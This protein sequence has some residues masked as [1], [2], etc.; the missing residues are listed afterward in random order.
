MRLNVGVIFGGK[1]VEHEISIISATEIMGFMDENKYKVIPIYIDKDNVWY[2]G[3]HLK[4]IINYRD[5]ALVKRYAKRVA[6]V[7]T[8]H[9]FALQTLGFIKR[10]V[11]PVDVILPIGHGTFM[12]DGSLQGYLNMIG[13]PYCGCGVTASAIG[14]DKVL[15]KEVLEFNGI[16]TPKYVWF[17]KKEWVNDRKAIL[18]KLNDF[19]YPLFVK[20]ASLGSSIGISKVD[21]ESMLSK[22][23]KDALVYDKKIIIEEGIRN[24]KEVNISVLGD[25][26]RLEVSGIEEINSNDEFYTFKEKYVSDCSKLSKNKV[27]KSKPIISKEMI[28]DLKN[29]ALRTFKTINAS[30]VARIDFLVDEKNMKIY[31]NEINTIPG[32][33]AGWLWIEKKKSQSELVD[34]LINLAI[35]KYKNSKDYEYTIS[36]NLLEQFDILDGK[37]INRKK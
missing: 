29:L 8:G 17:Y 19:S 14:Q 5:I 4:S 21:N 27:R 25:Y 23:I 10:N 3:D 22:A 37:K 2:T 31:V 33:L 9:G 28:E 11:C 18:D 24:V 16:P 32:D 20:P 12:E 36:G 1:S 35:K 26:E 34:D 6:L 30:G 7:N 13:I 15:M